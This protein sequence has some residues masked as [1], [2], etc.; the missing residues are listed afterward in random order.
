[1]K[2]NKRLVKA[3]K[4]TSLVLAIEPVRK[5]WA[6]LSAAVLLVAAATTMVAAM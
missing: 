6:K 5:K 2:A 1:M 3:E 4:K